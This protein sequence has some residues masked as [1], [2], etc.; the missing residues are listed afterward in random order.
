MRKELGKAEDE[1]NLTHNLRGLGKLL[2]NLKFRFA[3][4]DGKG[5]ELIAPLLVTK[6]SS[7]QVVYECLF[8]LWLCSFTAQ[9]VDHDRLEEKEQV[10]RHERKAG[11]TPAEKEHDQQVID[12]RRKKAS[13]LLQPEL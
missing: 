4:I 10:R 8:C 3:F 11:W 7:L 2:K 5:L 12:K 9:D 13:A 6:H 1:G